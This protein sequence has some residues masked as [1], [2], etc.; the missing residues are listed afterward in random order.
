MSEHKATVEYLS[1]VDTHFV[2]MHRGHGVQVAMQGLWMLRDVVD[3]ATLADLHSGLAVG[4]LNR[5]AVRPRI[6]GGRHYWARGASIAPV[7]RAPQPIRREDIVDWADERAQV[8][9]NPEHGIGWEFS[10]ARL[11]DGGMVMSLVCSH[12]LTDAQGMIAAVRAAISGDTA[13]VSDVPELPATRLSIWREL[14]TACR[15]YWA[16]LAGAFVAF[17]TIF[18]QGSNRD[19]IVR[20]LRLNR[21]DVLRRK[22]A[23]T[24]AKSGRLDES[25][26][27]PATIIDVDAAE[28][29]AVAAKS[30]GTPN[31]LLVGI[32]ANLLFSSG[33]RT[34]NETV[35]IGVPVDLSE[36]GTIAGRTPVRTNEL[37]IAPVTLRPRGTRYGELFLVRDTCRVAFAKAVA[38]KFPQDARP[39]SMPTEILDIV[40]DRIAARLV[41]TTGL[42]DA[43]ATYV[44]ELPEGLTQL[45]PYQIEST[46]ARAVH[47]GLTPMA[48]LESPFSLDLCLVRSGSRY[49]LSVIGVNPL[50][51]PDSKALRSLAIRELE[52]WGLVPQSWDSDQPGLGRPGGPSALY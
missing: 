28:W 9:L 32:A 31:S 33:A 11:E 19:E 10:V 46:A 6:P 20:Y 30:G 38:E 50:R 26:R 25:W 1:I 43:V 18:I 15:Q 45:G 39:A 44:G 7:H 16:L 24:L 5:R 40:P 34:A 21:I 17:Y 52:K 27:E 47:P 51:F 3:E 36:L 13:S 8:R 48:A 23:V 49:T 29:D 37:T 42:A 12:A 41:R 14:A 2:R 4:P 35:T 22:R